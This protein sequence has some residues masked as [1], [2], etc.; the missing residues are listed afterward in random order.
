MAT[1]IA[2]LT[3]RTDQ[4]EDED[5]PGAAVTLSTLHAAKGLEF[6][7][8][9]L[10]GCVEGVLP[11]ARTTDP[12]ATDAAPTDVEEERRLFYVGVTRARERLFLCRP[13]RRAMRGKASPLA[14]SR[15]LE[16][17][18]AEAIEEIEDVATAPLATDEISARASAFLAALKR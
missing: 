6:P 7:T 12:K 2:R 11:H 14:P 15:F 10:V 13:R 1:V 17:L 3:L 5:E 9:F 18:P 16:E 8:V 4:D